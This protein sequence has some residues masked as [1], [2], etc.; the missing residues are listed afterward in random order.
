MG[1]RAIIANNALQTCLSVNHV[2]LSRNNFFF[3]FFQ[4]KQYSFGIF[5][6][7]VSFGEYIFDLVKMIQGDQ[8]YVLSLEDQD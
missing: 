6:C 3:V 1:K 4:N 2:M 8:N 5:A 7:F